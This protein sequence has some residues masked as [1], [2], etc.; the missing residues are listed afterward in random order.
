M[1]LRG[2]GELCDSGALGPGGCKE[3]F[4]A[5]PCQSEDG[6][7]DDECPAGASKAVADEC[8]CGRGNDRD[9][10]DDHEHY[11]CDG[12]N[13]GLLP[14]F[15]CRPQEAMSMPMMMPVASPMPKFTCQVD[16][17]GFFASEFGLGASIFL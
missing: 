8:H 10:K 15:L 13:A 14:V 1:I 4:E 16:C 9:E 5:E 3:K 2:G 11:N 12:F 6:D 17:F 7:G